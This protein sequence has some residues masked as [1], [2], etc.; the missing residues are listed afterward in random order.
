MWQLADQLAQ[1]PKGA[2]GV[3]IVMNEI[4][5][6]CSLQEPG[7]QLCGYLHKQSQKGPLKVWK[8]RWCVVAELL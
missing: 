4:L 8:T 3:A 1:L 6:S 5:F 7:K 2:D